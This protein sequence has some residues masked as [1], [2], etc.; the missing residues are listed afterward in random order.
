MYASFFG[1]F[2]IAKILLEHQAF[3]DVKNEVSPCSRLS[4]LS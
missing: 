3:V 2:R 4:A 1:H